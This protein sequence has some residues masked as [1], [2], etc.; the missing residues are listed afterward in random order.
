ML[1]VLLSCLTLV[2]C[3]VSSFKAS[4]GELP[5]LS[6]G[7]TVAVGNL[8]DLSDS[9][10]DNRPEMV[11]YYAKWCAPCKLASNSL[12]KEM[13]NLPFRIRKVD[14]DTLSHYDGQVPKFVW[15]TPSGKVA[16]SGWYGIEFLKT[17]FNKS[18]ESKSQTKATKRLSNSQLKE[19]LRTYSD[20]GREWGV[21]GMTFYEHLQD[22]NHGFTSEQLM[23]LSQNEL[24][25]LHSAHHNGFVTPTTIIE[26]LTW[27]TD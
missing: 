18:R 24:A 22:S 11:Y 8:P 2:I 25:K 23:G 10:A 5:T 14:V 3:Q 27:L 26:R 15:D 16:L 7:F 20:R 13:G 6:H 19:Y 1:S 4:K 9:R 21:K 17:Q 12:T